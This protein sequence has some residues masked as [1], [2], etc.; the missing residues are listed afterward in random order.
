MG[1]IRQYFPLCWFNVSVFDLPRST[2]FFKHNAIF[3]FIAV[4]FIQ[5]NMSDDIDTIFEV[6]LETGLTLTFIALVLWLNQTFHLYVQVASAILFC[7]NVVALF[8]IPIVFWVT[9]AEDAPSYA[10]LALFLLWDMAIIARIFK[11]VLQINTPASL[12]VSLVYFLTTY[13]GAYGIYS[14]A[15]V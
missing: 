1:V 5:F 8:L 6:L 13:G 10:M 2:R 15:G 12:V 7:E 3:Y 14:L 4:F 9:V 11:D